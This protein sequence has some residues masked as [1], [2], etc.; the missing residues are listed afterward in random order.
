MVSNITM[1]RNF[2]IALPVVLLI[3]AA[4]LSGAE[5][6]ANA[7]GLQVKD[8]DNKTYRL[9]D[10]SRRASVLLFIAHD[11]P[12][13]NTYA[14]EIKRIC[15]QYGARGVRF[16]LVYSEADITAES[17]RKHAAD[18]GYMC[19]IVLDA[20]HSLARKLH[21]TVTPEAVVLDSK[22]KQA[23]RGRIDDLYAD[24]GTRRYEVSRH[25]LRLALDA[26]LN[27]KKI[28]PATTR[29]VGCIIPTK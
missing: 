1:I 8:I 6:G 3:A 23:Y 29:A 20:N 12:I 28:S 14:P 13:A 2:V 11:C 17:A 15:R 4:P 10:G 24:V 7:G 27:G 22:G 19:P 18:Y 25:D 16:I 9:D 26:L 21:A 5:N